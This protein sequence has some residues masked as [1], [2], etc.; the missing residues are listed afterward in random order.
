MAKENLIMS[1]CMRFLKQLWLF[2]LLP[3]LTFGVAAQGGGNASSNSPLRFKESVWD[4]G[5]IEEVAGPAKHVFEFTN[6]GSKAVVVEHVAVSCGCT[7]PEY[8]REPILPGQKGKITIFYDPTN[9]P[10]AFTKE[11]TVSSNGGASRDVLQ[12]KGEVIQRPRTMEEDYPHELGNGLRINNTAVNFGSVAQGTVASMT[13]KYINTGEKAVAL[14]TGIEPAQ[15]WFSVSAPKEICAGCR[16]EITL[17]Y[18][19]T[20]HEVW[21]ALNHSVTLAVDGKPYR[22]PI[23]ATGYG[24]DN[25]PSDRKSAPNAR[26]EKQF[27]NFGNVE[28][29]KPLTSNH[30][31]SNEG[32]EVLIVRAVKSNPGVKCSLRPGTEI[33]PGKSLSFSITLTPANYSGGR[34]YENVTVILN[35]PRSPVRD[36]RL[37]AEV[38]K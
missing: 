15:P 22:Y 29:D 32:G 5:R 3:L 35:D 8:S 14:T 24:V 11:I 26:F 20:K 9:R 31:L 33:K 12:I 27:V 37:S 7:T 13:I 4:F 36:I 23:H 25:F 1:F 10:G 17:T 16:S 38:K 19:L 18:D 34:I 2:L 21:G 28:R 30:T 6:R